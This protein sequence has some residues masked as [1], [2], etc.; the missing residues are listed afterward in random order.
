MEEVASLAILTVLALCGVYRLLCRI[1]EEVLRRG[2]YPPRR[3][4]T[5]K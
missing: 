1:A 5:Q 3:E 2:G 4:G